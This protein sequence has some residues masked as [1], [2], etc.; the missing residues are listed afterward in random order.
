MDIGTNIDSTF[1]GKTGTGIHV[2]VSESIMEDSGWIYFIGSPT[3][4]TKGTT[5]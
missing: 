3:S 4:L 5:S 1:I 2:S